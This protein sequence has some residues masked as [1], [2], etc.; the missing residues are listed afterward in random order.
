MKYFI[1][2]IICVLATPALSEGKTV[3][4]KDIVQFAKKHLSGSQD[5]MLG[6]ICDAKTC[7]VYTEKGI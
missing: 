4:R 5:R 3:A 7:V 6:V 1:A 2:A